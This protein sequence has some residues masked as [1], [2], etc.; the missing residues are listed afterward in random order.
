MWRSPSSGAPPSEHHAA[1]G[2][3]AVTTTSAPG[4]NTAIVPEP[5]RRA[6]ICDRSRRRRAPPRWGCVAV[7]RE[8]APASS[9]ASHVEGGRQHAHRRPG[10]VRGAGDD[11]R[12]RRRPRLDLRQRG[13]R[14][15][16]EGRRVL[17][18][19]GGQRDPALDA[20]EAHAARPLLRAAPLRVGDAAPGEHPVHVARVDGPLACRGC[21]GGRSRPRRGRS[22]WPARCA[23]AGARPSRA[24]LH[25]RRA[26]VVEE[27]ERPDHAVRRRREQRAGRRNRRDLAAAGR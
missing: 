16:L 21:R 18:V 7:H 23:D 10:P 17:L 15:V 5:R 9:R 12:A 14:V 25:H 2:P 19:G 13:R 4:R 27:D 20:V 6:P 1:A 22:P 11:R 8:R 26:H 3:S 24:L